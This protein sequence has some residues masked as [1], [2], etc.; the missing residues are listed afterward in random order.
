[1]GARLGIRS[2]PQHLL[3]LPGGMDAAD[4]TWFVAYRFESTVATTNNFRALISKWNASESDWNSQFCLYSTFAADRLSV[5]LNHDL[6]L[7]TVAPVVGR[8]YVAVVQLVTSP[9]RLAAQMVGA[10]LFASAAR[11]AF[12]NDTRHP[13]CLGGVFWPSQ[14]QVYNGGDFVIHEVRRYDAV[15]DASQIAAVRAQ[16]LEKWA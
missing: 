1:V 14:N 10:T 12:P 4:R 15:L 6:A 16:L 8:L 7:A 9:A 11:G 2:P 3:M 5:G 13:W